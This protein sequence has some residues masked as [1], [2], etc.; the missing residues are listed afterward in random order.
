MR[1]FSAEILTLEFSPSE[2]CVDAW[3]VDG[4]NVVVCPSQ[5]RTAVYPSL[6]IFVRLAGPRL[7]Q[8]GGSPYLPIKRIMQLASIGLEMSLAMIFSSQSR[9]IVGAAFLFGPLINRRR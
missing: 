7:S 3:F 9:S 4:A 2:A 5:E 6:K 1:C 8:A